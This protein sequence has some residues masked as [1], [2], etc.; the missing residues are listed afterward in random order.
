MK[1]SMPVPIEANRFF[2]TGNKNYPAFKNCILERG[3]IL[4]LHNSRLSFASYV[5]VGMTLT[6]SWK[7]GM[8]EVSWTAVRSNEVFQKS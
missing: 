4:I 5:K 3:P 7:S 6:N 1:I 8:S 2:V